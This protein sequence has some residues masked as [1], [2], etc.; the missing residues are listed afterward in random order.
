MNSF[1]CN[2]STQPP[3]HLSASNCIQYPHQWFA[4]LTDNEKNFW[5]LLTQA[6]I[7]TQSQNISSTRNEIYTGIQMFAEQIFRNVFVFHWHFNF[8]LTIAGASVLYI[9]GNWWLASHIMCAYCAQYTSVCV[10]RTHELKK[11]IC[12]QSKTV[13]NLVLWQGI[14]SCPCIA[15]ICRCLCVRCFFI[16]SVGFSISING[17]STL[18]N[19]QP[20]N[21]CETLKRWWRSFA[22]VGAQSAHRTPKRRWNSE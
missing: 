15:G 3:Q 20:T 11:Y 22:Y 9:R 2:Y 6:Q 17:K 5:T 1:P 8:T 18:I 7:Q 13:K 4:Q 12:I 21:T 16:I 10:M 19:N 14:F